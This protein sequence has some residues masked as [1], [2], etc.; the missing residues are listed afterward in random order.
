MTPEQIISLAQRGKAALVASA[1]DNFNG[2]VRFVLR[3]E[4]TGK[5]IKQAWLHQKWNDL[6]MK[7]QRLV[8][9]SHVEA[10]KGCVTTAPILTSH[11]W[12]TIG[13]L[14][15]GDTVYGSDGN[16]CTVTAK[17]PIHR[18][19]CYKVLFTDGEELTFDH[20]HRWVA[21]TSGQ[22]AKGTW[23]D[24]DGNPKIVTT[25]DI[26]DRKLSRDRWA[27]PVAKPLDLPAQDLPIDPY[28][29]G[30][31]LGDGEADR[32]GFTCG[33]MFIHEEI[34]RREGLSEP[35]WNG[36]GAWVSTI[37]PHTAGEDLAQCATRRLRGLGVLGD[38]HV[39]SIYLRGSIQQRTD[40]LMGLLDTDGSCD[41]KGRVEFTQKR[42]H[43]AQ[44][45]RELCW[46][47]GI[48]CGA[49]KPKVVNG[50][51]YWRVHFRPH[52]PVFKL[53]RK[54]QD[55]KLHSLTDKDRARAAWRTIESV[56][57]CATVETQ[58]LT[59]DSPDHTF[60]SGR[61]HIVSHNTQQLSVALA[62]FTLGRNPRTRIAIISNT[63][64]QSKKIVA[65]IKGYIEKSQ[66]LNAVFPDLV[67]GDKWAEA[68]ITVK[69]EGSIKEPSIQAFGATGKITGARIDLVIVDDIHGEDN[70]STKDQ[71]DKIHRWF[72]STPM[73]RLTRK[74]QVI[75]VGN[76]WHPDDMLHRL[77]HE[78][79]PTYR[80]PV[81]VTDELA[82]KFPKDN[83][84]VGE[85]TWRERWPQGRID[86]LRTGTPEQ[87]PIPPIEFA[88]A[89]MC[90]ARDDHDARFKQAWMDRA[91]A[92]G[93]KS[94]IHQFSHSLRDLL[95]EEEY[96]EEEAT[97]EV[98]DIFLGMMEASPDTTVRL[99]TGVDLSTG[100]AKDLSV[101]FTIMVYPNGD[102]RVLNIE[103]G[104][105]QIDEIVARVIGCYKRFG[106][107]MMVENNN[108]QQW[109]AQLLIKYTSIPLHPITTGRQKADPIFGVESLA[110]E[111]ANGKWIIP[112]KNGH[113]PDEA[114][115]WI[116]EMLYYNPK[117]HTGDRL[118]AAWFARTGAERA[119]RSNPGRVGVTICG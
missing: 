85:P 82:A 46:S 22:R 116:E 64:D 19:Q 10:G 76:A 58:C 74:A 40:L 95:L 32:A 44:S 106:S 107:I 114:E 56:T 61:T 112:A 15:V 73:S 93:E 109:L 115:A 16:P 101:L 57:P 111:L 86:E 113:A 65:T 26:F 8:L 100:E 67:P 29:L 55:Q 36:K 54:R 77:E 52:V 91:K 68:V 72:Y 3:D 90:V 84:V 96:T 17:S 51:T 53:P 7:H 60:C 108:T 87:P 38:K 104:R 83:L 5:R 71:R 28:V 79:W 1:R 6:R 33:D 63:Q 80:F 92:R 2:F 89:Y 70:V 12:T 13:G 119:E 11:G 88:R 105:W 110:A 27:V 69:R 75:I 102:R 18:I 66:A 14:G 98:D 39:P 118:M 99:Y 94:S 103:S 25:Q 34:A 23:L 45:V 59:V 78:G 47:L 49:L 41:H 42:E 97:T 30:A 50:E 9:L 24:K 31:W 62:L 43:M 21:A 35:K 20:E 4:E 117:Q 48:K 81:I 37:A